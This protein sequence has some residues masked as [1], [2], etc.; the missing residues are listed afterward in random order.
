MAPY[1]PSAGFAQLATGREQ[2]SLRRFSVRETCERR[3]ESDN[4]CSA[5]CENWRFSRRQQVGEC[6]EEI[7]NAPLFYTSPGCYVNR[8]VRAGFPLHLAHR[9]QQS[10]DVF[11]ANTQHDFGF[12]ETFESFFQLAR[13]WI[14]VRV[15]GRLR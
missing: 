11:D 3:P 14:A 9:L 13:I 2:W 10:F 12:R 8:R 7:V 4:G 6:G 5:F 15:F 1:F